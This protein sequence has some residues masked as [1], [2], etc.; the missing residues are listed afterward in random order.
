MTSS[1][2]FGRKFGIMMYDMLL[3]QARVRVKMDTASI[4]ASRTE[5]ADG[6]KKRRIAVESRRSTQGSALE[7]CVF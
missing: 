6:G 1:A 2:E 3:G 5:S 7:H 4:I